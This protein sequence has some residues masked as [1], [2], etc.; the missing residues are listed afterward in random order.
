M[1]DDH[2]R[3]VQISYFTKVML[4]QK[5][6]GWYRRHVGDPGMPQRVMVGGRPMLSLQACTAFVERL[7]R[8]AAPTPPEMKRGPGRP[9]KSFTLPP[10]AA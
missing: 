6:R 3:F 8:T 10:S 2:D 7:K 9:R 4:G 1:T 5:D